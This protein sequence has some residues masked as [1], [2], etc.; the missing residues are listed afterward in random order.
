M[1]PF[2]CVLKD[3]CKTER[4]SGFGAVRKTL[5][6]IGQ[7]YTSSFTVGLMFG[8]IFSTVADLGMP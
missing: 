6:R 1:F 4:S 7:V 5:P 2:V 3:E 8:K